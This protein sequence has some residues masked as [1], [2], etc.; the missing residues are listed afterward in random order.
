MPLRE[1]GKKGFR[2]L[3]KGKVNLRKKGVQGTQRVEKSRIEGG[4]RGGRKKKTTSAKIGG[5]EVERKCLLNK[6]K[7]SEKKK[8]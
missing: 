1:A 5:K 7:P 2:E 4:R 3:K 6:E 8:N